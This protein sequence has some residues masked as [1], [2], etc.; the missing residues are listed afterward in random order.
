[1]ISPG[2][3]QT[4]AAYNAEMNRRLYAAAARLPDEARRQERGAFFGSIHATLSHLVWADR[5]WMSRFALWPHPEGGI[6]GSTTLF[7]EFAPM[8]AARAALDADIIAWAATLPA[9]WLE[10]ELEWLSGATGRRQCRPKPLL[11]THM[12]NHQTHHRGQIHAML[13]A[14]GET[15]GDTDLPFILPAD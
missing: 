10:G 12:F 2:Y 13:T 6:P 9:A 4:M 8:R 1:M 7:A 15:T 3:V 14:A 5:I 11:V